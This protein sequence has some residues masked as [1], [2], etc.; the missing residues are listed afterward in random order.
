MIK[1]EH[2]NCGVCQFAPLCI[3]QPDEK[4]KYFDSSLPIQRHISLHKGE[5]LFTPRTPFQSLYAIQS[6]SIK[7]TQIE[8]DGKE[9]I[10]NFYFTGD[11]FGYKALHQGMYLSTATALSESDVCEIDYRTFLSF[12][13]KNHRL[14]EHAIYTACSHINA[15]AYLHYN[16]AERRLAAFLLDLS[17]RLHPN[18]SKDVLYLPMSRQDIANYLKLTPETISRISTKYIQNKIIAVDK[19]KITLLHY[20]RLREIAEKGRV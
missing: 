7:T 16:S 3:A 15:T 1:N 9:I 6:G 18:F 13:E 20:E 2:Q 5:V 8:D 11:V 14:Q 19:R 10:R 12:L 17:N 4:Y